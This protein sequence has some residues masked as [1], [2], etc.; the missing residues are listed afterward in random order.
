MTNLKTRIQRLEQKQPKLLPP[1]ILI[2]QGGARKVSEA[3]KELAIAEF[4]AQHGVPPKLT[5]SVNF[6]PGRS[7]TPDQQEI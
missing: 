5:I 3:D 4:V 2:P 1:L 6:V 7:D